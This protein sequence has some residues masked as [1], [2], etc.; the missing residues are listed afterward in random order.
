MSP[1]RLSPRRIA[2][3]LCAFAVVLLFSNCQEALIWTPYTVFFHRHTEEDRRQY[4]SS[5]FLIQ[6]L[7][8]VAALLVLCLV[9]AVAARGIVG[10]SK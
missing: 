10:G 7:S 5:V 6:F 9:V 2:V 4:T 8:T 3:S 1:R